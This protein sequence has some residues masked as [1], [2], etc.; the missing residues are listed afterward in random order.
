[1][2]QYVCLMALGTY[3]TFANAFTDIASSVLPVAQGMMQNQQAG[4]AAQQQQAQAM[5]QIQVEQNQAS[6]ALTQAQSAEMANM[7]AQEKKGY[8]ILDPFARGTYWAMRDTQFKT[9]MAIAAKRSELETKASKEA[10]DREFQATQQMITA[11]G[12]LMKTAGEQVQ[13]L[14]QANASA[15]ASAKA[16]QQAQTDATDASVQC[17]GDRTQCVRTAQPT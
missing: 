3:A 7:A 5:A 9:S 1:M 13:K 10:I 16:S 8:P 4:Q 14:G 15:A 17:N 6:Q 12:G 11:V 2:R